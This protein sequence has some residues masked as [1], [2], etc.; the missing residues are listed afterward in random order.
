MDIGYEILRLHRQAGKLGK[1]ITLCQ[2]QID[3]CLAMLGKHPP[4]RSGPGR[5]QEKGM[6]EKRDITI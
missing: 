4:R 3:R 1:Q 5:K 2:A 6:E